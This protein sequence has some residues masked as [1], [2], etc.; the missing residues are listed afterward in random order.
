MEA[1]AVVRSSKSKATRPLFRYVNKHPPIRIRH[2]G[3][4]MFKRKRKRSILK[5]P[6]D[7]DP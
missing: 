5:F 2:F 4:D 3:V 6:I 7:T 1:T